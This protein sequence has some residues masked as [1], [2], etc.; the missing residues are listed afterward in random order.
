MKIILNDEKPI[1]LSPYQTPFRLQQE[2]TDEIN[3]LLE[4]GIIT[5]SK[6][7]FVSPAFIIPKKDRKVR[8]VVDYR[9]I[10]SRTL[11]DPY[12]FPDMHME[13]RSIPQSNW[14]SKIDLSMGYHQVL[15]DKESC[16]YTSFVTSHWHFGYTR[17]PFGLKNAPRVFQRIIREIIGDLPFV[18]IFLDDILVFSRSREEHIHHVQEILEILYRNNIAISLEKSCFVRNSITYLG[19][20]ISQEGLQPAVSTLSNLRKLS[21]QIS[22]GKSRAR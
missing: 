14:F 3:H 11:S 8:L 21:V 6:S 22:L 12:Q 5:K 16:K 13:L 19:H 2:L 15:M 20:I 4:L 10:N 18:K 17:V 7:Q 9:K 1:Y